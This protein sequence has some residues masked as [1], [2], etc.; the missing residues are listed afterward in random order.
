MSG[1]QKSS[2]C[3][4]IDGLAR[5]YRRSSP[6][7]RRKRTLRHPSPS[8][9]VRQPRPRLRAAVGA[10]AGPAPLALLARSSSLNEILPELHR[11]AL[12]ASHGIRA[13]LFL[14][15]T[16]SGALHA[17]SG[18]GL[19]ALPAIPWRPVPPEA[20][21]VA[22]T[23]SRPTPT[24]VVDAKRQAPELFARL[25]AAP[26][27][28]LPLAHGADRL[29]LLAI[30][31]REPPSAHD[32]DG[33][34][35]QIA[36]AFVAALQFFALRQNAALQRDIDGLLTEFAGILGSTLNLGSALDALCRGTNRLFGADRTGVWVHNRRERRLMLRASSEGDHTTWGGQ[37]DAD[38]ARFPVAA[39]MRRRHAEIQS[40]DG[41]PTAT[42][43]VPLRGCRRAIGTLMLEGVRVEA[44]DELALLDRADA[45]GRRL[46]AAVEN[47]QLL[48]DVRSRS[49]LTHAK[50]LVV[51]GQFV[52]SIAH[53]LNNPLQGVLRHLDLLRVSR[54]LPRPI[55]QEIETV[56]Q[57]A[58]QAVRIV[59][60]LVAFSGSRRHRRRSVN[61]K[62]VLTKIVKLRAPVC[63][64]TDVDL[65]HRWKG[66]L[67]RVVGD[68][69]LLQQ[70]FLNIVLNAE[71]AI[72]ETGRNG[73]IEIESSVSS[74]GEWVTTSVRDTGPGIAVDTLPRVFE[75]FHATKEA[76]QGT[77]LGLAIAFGIMRDHGGDVQAANHPEG[78][79]IFTVALPV[80]ESVRSTD[81][82]PM[83]T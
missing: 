29:G 37:I 22:E 68:P 51:L 69:R 45:L 52:A 26:I 4:T 23:F 32:L 56:Y 40:A 76:G 49:E 80:A 9:V 43:T 61:L 17:T 74:G 36:D 81:E 1:F 25:G 50:K 31:L 66:K 15:N 82:D 11:R 57:E 77:G 72:A 27:L 48:D 83:G 46:A 67:P 41:S 2:A 75:P 8:E 78:G 60:D 14:H 20:G 54:A 35:S 6:G 13:L 70:V 59:R 79:A 33:D 55:R 19:D 3:R 16:R 53:E 73:R 47:M 5:S 44:G 71:Q 21:L 18:Y 62:E 58:D 10:A 42:I 24:L 63:R 39:A 7:V 65:V 12:V 28:L 38:D 30:A 34:L 64:A